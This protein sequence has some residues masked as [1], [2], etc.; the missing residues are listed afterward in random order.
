MP[1][2]RGHGSGELRRSVCQREA[3]G[4]SEDVKVTANNR[5]KTYGET[6]SWARR[7]SR[8]PVWSN[9]DTVTR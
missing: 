2:R 4:G 5:T 8:P 9:G 1:R 6:L 7:G 3:D